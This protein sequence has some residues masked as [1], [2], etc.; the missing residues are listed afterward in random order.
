MNISKNLAGMSSAG[1]ISIS[2][3]VAGYQRRDQVLRE[4]REGVNDVGSGIVPMDGGCRHYS[5][6]RSR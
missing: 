1:F 5:S 6:L 4:G 2:E 3:D